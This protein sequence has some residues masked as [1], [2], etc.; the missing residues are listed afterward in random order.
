VAGTPSFFVNGRRHQGAYDLETLTLAVKTARGR[1]VA[2]R[3]ASSRGPI[4]TSR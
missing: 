1:E 3:Q 2:A 4:S